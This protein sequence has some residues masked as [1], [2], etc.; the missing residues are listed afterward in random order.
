MCAVILTLVYFIF[1][2]RMYIIYIYISVMV[3]LK[4]NNMAI[5]IPYVCRSALLLKTTIYL[6]T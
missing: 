5:S 3:E 4:L 6:A 1:Y 2:K